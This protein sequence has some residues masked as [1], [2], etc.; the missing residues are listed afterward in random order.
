MSTSLLVALIVVAAAACPLHMWWQERR[1][2]RAAC[3]APRKGS[4]GAGDVDALRSRQEELGRQL[5]LVRESGDA[6]RSA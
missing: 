4:E 2:R 1:G 6:H 3:C 5:A